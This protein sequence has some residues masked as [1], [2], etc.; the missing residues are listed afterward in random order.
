MALTVT[1]DLVNITT[2]ETVTGWTTYGSGGAGALALEPDFFSQGA[3]CISRGVSGAVIKGMTFDIGAGATLDFNSGTHQDKLVYIWMRT[4]TPALCE[5]YSNGGI[6]VV[7]GSGATAPADGVGVWSAWYV[8]GSNTLLATEGWICYVIDP[9]STASTTFGGG[10]DLNAVRWFGGAQRS[11]G[12]A[13]GQNF[14]IDRISYGR[15]ELRVTG[16]VTTAGEGFKEIAATDF[17]DVTNGRWGIIKERAGVFYVRGKI[18]IGHATSNTTFSSYGEQVVWESPAYYNGSAA[19]ATI[20]NASV[21]GVT[22]VDGKTSYNGLAFTGGS[23]T[24]L[25]DLGIIVGSDGGRSGSVLSSQK[26][27]F[28]IAARTLATVSADDATMTLG[29]YGTTF[30]GFEGAIDLRGTGIDDDDCFNNNFAECGRIDSNMEMRNC[31][32]LNSKASSTDGAYIW[33]STTNLEKCLFAGCSRATVFESTSGTP[34][35]FTNITFSGNTKDVRNESLGA[36][37]INVSGGTTPTTE[38]IG[39]GSAT[40]VASSV[41]VTVTVV[42]FTD[43]AIQNAQVG[44]FVGA[45]QVI[46]ADTNASGVATASYSGSVPANAIYKVRKSSSGN[47]KYVSVSGPAVIAAG[48]GMSVKVVLLVDGNA[49]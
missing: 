17:G 42:D 4:S 23:G 6:R 5:T 26:G 11:T 31:N 8:D 12:T 7:L 16:T 36:I 14:G 40:T 43:V 29:L 34:F 25:I 35:S 9:Q 33:T 41:T 21:G 15:G 39:V 13:K 32:I 24:T 19:T 44:V 28:T 22:G 2:A 45:T 18:S 10:V 49:T 27:I 46:N 3:N 47:P 38:D 37:T 1:T 20:P 48:T 30:N